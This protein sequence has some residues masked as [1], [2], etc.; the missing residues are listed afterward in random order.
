MRNIYIYFMQK[1][2]T[3]HI[4]CLPFVRYTDI[5]ISFEL[6]ME[7]LPEENTCPQTYIAHCALLFN[8]NLRLLLLHN[9]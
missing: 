1:V 4:S 5:Y 2:N 9:N 8:W 7:R 6:W 3:S